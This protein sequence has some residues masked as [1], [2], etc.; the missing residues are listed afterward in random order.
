MSILSREGDSELPWDGRNH[1]ITLML[2]V[3]SN[4]KQLRWLKQQRGLADAYNLR[5]SDEGRSFRYGLIRAWVLF[6]SFASEL[7]LAH[8][9]TLFKLENNLFWADTIP[10]WPGEMSVGYMKTGPRYC[11]AQT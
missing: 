3:I 8:I 7:P 4:K 5:I 1:F 2:L 9:V 11:K 10:E 6:P